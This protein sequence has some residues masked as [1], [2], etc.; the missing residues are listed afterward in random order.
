MAT[1][2]SEVFDI[3]MDLMDETI[4]A[5]TNE[6]RIRTLRILN[7]LRG[8]LYPYSDTYD[9]ND[10][11]RPIATKIKSLDSVIDLDDYICQTVMP[12]GLAAHLIMDENPTSANFFQQRY[13]ELVSK[14]S[15]GM[16]AVSQ[17]IEDVCFGFNS[18]YN[19]FSRW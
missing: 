9:S 15:R 18:E 10:T 19:E 2:A 1:K 7:L 6:Y 13:E 8:E 5:D 17:D 12:Y 16:P 14:L 4:A 11:G 3:A